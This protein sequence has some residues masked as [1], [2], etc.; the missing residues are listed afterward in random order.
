MRLDCL[1][2]LLERKEISSI[3]RVL[4]CAGGHDWRSTALLGLAPVVA[5]AAGVFMTVLFVLAV[6]S[7]R[8]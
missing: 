8:R 7:L 6:R 2:L 5:L 3:E 1:G 4:V